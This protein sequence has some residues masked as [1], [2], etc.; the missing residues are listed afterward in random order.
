M[1]LLTTTLIMLA[2][3]LGVEAQKQ[4][5]YPTSDPYSDAYARMHYWDYA[6]A[7]TIDTAAIKQIIKREI[8]LG[9]NDQLHVAHMVKSLTATHITFNQYYKGAEVIGGGAKVAVS[10]KTN[11]LFRCIETLFNTNGNLGTLPASFDPGS[12]LSDLSNISYL[13]NHPAYIWNGQQVVAGWFAQFNH[14]ERGFSEAAWNANGDLIFLRDKLAYMD[15]TINAK[16]FDPD[17]IT[18]INKIYGGIYI[19]ANDG[20]TSVLDPLRKNV[21]VRASFNNGVFTLENAH[22]QIVE[23]DAPVNPVMTKSTT[24]FF[25]SRSDVGFEQVNAFYH[26]TNY[27][28]YLQLLGYSLVQYPIQV[29]AQGWNG[30]DNSS[31]D[32]STQPYPSLSFG[33]GGVDDAEDADVVVHEYGHAISHS[34]SPN[35]NIGNERRS[36]DEAFGDYVAVSYKKDVYSFGSNRVFNWDGHN[37]FWDG[38]TVNN[39]NSICYDNISSFGNIYAYTTVFNAAMFEIWSQLGKIYTDKLMIEALHGYFQ[40]MTYR[41]AAFMVLD[42]DSMLTGGGSNTYTIYDAFDNHCILNWS[43]VDENTTTKQFYQLKQAQ[44]Y[45]QVYLF[46]SIANYNLIDMTG[47][48]VASGSLNGGENTIYTSELDAGIYILNVFDGQSSRAEKI[49]IAR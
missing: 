5:S 22:V 34:A 46:G 33:E 39:P 18:P 37:T 21:S 10:N 45:L 1:K 29:D 28:D 40:N 30:G 19:D 43:S 17:P 47:R 9:E 7:G 23:N 36:L 41:D 27:Q 24:D 32:A 16:V 14:D 42:A 26:I 49:M 15:T 31:F 20:N 25:Y 8:H 12:H 6:M 11:V 35:T 2:M 4:V 48:A 3:L 44:E 38:R 13:K